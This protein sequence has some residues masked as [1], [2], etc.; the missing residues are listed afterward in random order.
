MMFSLIE[1]L[2]VRGDLHTKLRT[3]PN[4]AEKVQG[5]EKKT[6]A[7]ADMFSWAVLH[8]YS[9]SMDAL[10]SQIVTSRESFASQERAQ[11]GQ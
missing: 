6:P 3:N 5:G 8:R 7:K 11:A 2:S 9:H 10:G 4:E 1:V